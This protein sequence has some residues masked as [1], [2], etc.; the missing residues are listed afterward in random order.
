[1]VVVLVVAE[2][3]ESGSRGKGRGKE[4]CDK[5]AVESKT[6]HVHLRLLKRA[7]IQYEERERGKKRGKQCHK[8]QIQSQTMFRPC[9]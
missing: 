5:C 8:N 3:E 9:I 4:V 1:M 2:G 7:R 6:V